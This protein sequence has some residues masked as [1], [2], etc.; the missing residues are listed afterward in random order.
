[1]GWK[2]FV[3]DQSYIVSYD[4]PSLADSH[5]VVGLAIA[6]LGAEIFTIHELIS[7]LQWV[8]AR[9]RQLSDSLGCGRRMVQVT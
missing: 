3:S 4:V 5:D 9:S 1:M 2:L 7:G 6:R 8:I